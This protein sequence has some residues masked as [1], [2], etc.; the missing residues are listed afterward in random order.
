MSLRGC[1]VVMGALLDARP[2]EGS[3]FFDT[4]ANF[5]PFPLDSLDGLDLAIAVVP[6]LLVESLLNELRQTNLFHGQ[7]VVAGR[8]D[9]RKLLRGSRQRQCFN[10][11]RSKQ[12]FP[13][14]VEEHWRAPMEKSQ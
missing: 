7:Q 9:V 10:G 4:G 6:V 8:V 14:R 5:D 12:V 11:F 3:S 2:L 1:G 13:T